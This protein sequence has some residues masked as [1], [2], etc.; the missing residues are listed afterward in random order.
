MR[1]TALEVL[2][3]FGTL[4]Q[5]TPYQGVR[6]YREILPKYHLMMVYDAAHAIDAD[7]PEAVASVVEDFLTRHEGFLVR[8]ER[9]IIHP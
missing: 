6:F 5:I 7:S 8:Q 9:D 1:P 3:L 4:E 2:A